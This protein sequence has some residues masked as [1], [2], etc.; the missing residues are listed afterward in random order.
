MKVVIAAVVITVAIIIFIYFKEIKSYI[1]MINLDGRQKDFIKDLQPQAQGI[2]A[3]FFSRIEKETNY[4]FYPTSGYR[5]YAKQAQLHLENSSN[6]PAGSSMHNFGLAIDGNGVNKETGVFELKKATDKQLWIDS[7]IPQI[8]ADLGLTWGGNFSNY[9]DPIHFGFDGVI[10][11]AELQALAASTYGL[12]PTK[13]IG[14][15]LNIVV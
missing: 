1:K 11:I 8:A 6:A 10:P 5:D 2:F 15:K 7:G 13:V 4:R 9:Y 12:D 14:N 3:A